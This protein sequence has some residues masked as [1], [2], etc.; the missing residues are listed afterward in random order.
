MAAGERMLVKG[1]WLER[2]KSAG[3]GS[4]AVVW[5]LCACGM[6]LYVYAWA[7]TVEEL[8]NI[9]MSP[10]TRAV[11]VVFKHGALGQAGRLLR[12]GRPAKAHHVRI[13]LRGVYGAKC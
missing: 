4:E 9:S 7:E 6:E 3:Q 13:D 2:V 1:H 11:R 10:C 5:L 12:A 8:E